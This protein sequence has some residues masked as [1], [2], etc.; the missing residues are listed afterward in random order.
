MASSEIAQ[1]IWSYCDTL[2]DDGI[3][4][5][6]YLE[7]ITYLLFLKMVDE[8][9]VESD[10]SKVTIPKGCDWKTLLDTD[11]SKIKETYSKNL[12][13]LSKAGG[14]LSKIFAESQNRI[15]DARKLKKLIDLINEE[16]WISESV[17]VKGEI[18]ESLLQKNA[19]NS[20]AGQYFTPRPIIQAMVECVNPK[21]LQKI[22]DPSC[23]TGGFF[24]GVINFL[25]SNFKLTSTQEK[26]IQFESF[27]GWEIV[28]STVRL[29]LMNLFLH[30]I[31]DL[32]D[33]PEIEVVDSLKSAPNEKVDIVLANPPFGKTSSDKATNDEKKAETSGYHFRKDFWDTTGNKQLAFVQ[34]IYTMLKKNGQAAVVVPDNVLFEAGVG[35]KVRKKLLEL[36]NFHTILRLPTGIFYA[37]GVK[38]NVIFF[39]K[40]SEGTKEIWV[41][42]YRTNI[43]HTLKKNTLKSIDLV[44]FVK[45]YNPQNR[46]KRKETWSEKNP[47]GRWRKFPVTELKKHERLTLDLNWIKDKNFINYDNLENPDIIAKEIIKNLESGLESFRKISL[48]IK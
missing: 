25:R 7:Q 44:D 14:M 33:T 3:S 45:C 42:D 16:H 39:E 23:G 6:D 30:G 27:H 15:Q 10:K 41:Y 31:G 40:K 22:A 48:L 13:K 18:Y 24:L 46:K 2:R 35:E 17:D 47:D 21:P 28:P 36:T 34:H 5:G 32:K 12:R 19:E 20:G 9:S 29:C 37:Q 11:N 4:Y 26:F 1:K 8:I 43:H 38:A